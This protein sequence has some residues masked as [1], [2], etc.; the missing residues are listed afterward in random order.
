MRARALCCLIETLRNTAAW[1]DSVHSFLDTL[2][3]GERASSL[4]LMEELMDRE[5]QNSRD[6]LE[7][8]K[9]TDVEWMIVAEDGETPFLYG[10][11]MPDLLERRISLME[12]HM[13]DI[14][15]VDPDY[16][17][18]VRNNPY[19]DTPQLEGKE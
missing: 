4:R 1:V 11:N 17:F 3:K 18:R 16:M 13:G 8:W 10:D 15:A 14:P 7:L 9:E 6:L 5:I 2:D 19:A 12:R